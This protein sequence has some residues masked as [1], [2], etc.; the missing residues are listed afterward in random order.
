[1]GRMKIRILFVAAAATLNVGAESGGVK[2]NPGHYVALSADQSVGDFPLLNEPAIRGVNRRYY[3]ADMEPRKDA[4]DFSA[5]RADLELLSKH[6]KQLVVFITDKTFS[7]NDPN[8]LPEYI[9]AHGTT[10]L[11]GAVS[12]KKWEPPLIDRQIALC[13]A[14]SKEFDAH[15]NFEGVAYQE[16]APSIPA[17]QLTAA[18][19]TPEAFRDEMIRLLAG[20]SRALPRS[21]VFWYMNFLPMKSE[22]LDEIA[23]AVTGHRIVIGGPDIL[24]HR[25]S[26]I[27]HYPI[28]ERF[29]GRL[30]LFCSAQADSFRHH[31]DDRN[32]NTKDAF[33]KGL[34]PIHTDG[35]VTM[36]EIFL[37]GRDQ[38]HLDYIFW[39]YKT[40]RGKP[41]PGDPQDFVF[42]DALAVIR[43]Y[44]AFPRSR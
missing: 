37:F 33:H 40:Y 19:Y 32:N 11:K 21:Q 12:P 15:P 9:R 34:K 26:L 1:M 43:K 35:Y 39:N 30:K 24:P 28:Y 10:N 29:K 18:G 14:L 41:H 3:W 8:P 44:A 22:Y 25:D 42:D 20:S 5:I 16:S 27:K 2:F 31:K 38:L 4:Y 36:E 7:P 6:G 17:A 13:L 23:G